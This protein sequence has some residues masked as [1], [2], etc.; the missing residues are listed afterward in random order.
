M[1][2][3]DRMSWWLALALL[4]IGST[5]LLLPGLF[6]GPSRDPAVF[7]AVARAILNGHVPYA[8]IWD[9]KAPGI[10]LI[11]AVA[12]LMTGSAG[13]LWPAAWLASLAATVAAACAA[14]VL[15]RRLGVRPMVAVL[16]GLATAGAS[17]QYAL[18]EGG[19][20]TEQA[21]L[22]FGAWALVAAVGASRR[23]LAAAGALSAL[24]LGTTPLLAPAVAAATAAVVV[25][26]RGSRA[27]ARLGWFAAGASAPIAM[28]L[29]WL[30]LRGGLPSAWDAIVTYNAAYRVTQAHVLD[31]SIA[32]VRT[33]A[34][35]LAFVLIPAALGSRTLA[36]RWKRTRSGLEVAI[37]I[38][39]AGGILMVAVQG[40]VYAHY[41]IP[42]AV[43]IAVLGSVGVEQLPAGWKRGAR[44]LTVATGSVCTVAV[45]VSLVT[46]TVRGA[47]LTAYNAAR[48]ARIGEVASEIDT[49]SSPGSTLFIWGNEPRLYEVARRAPAVRY[50]YLYPLTTPDYSTPDQVA[51]LVAS[52]ERAPPQIVVDAG[53]P[54]PGAPGVP[55]LLVSRPP[56]REGRN[57]DLLAPLR[58]FVAAHYSLAPRD[59]GWPI[60]TWS[61]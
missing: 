11:D 49:L 29:T 34:A 37:A 14:V 27:P 9:H 61:H 26:R 16:G 60:Y 42:L 56:D 6:V 19:G 31:R 24:A 28:V 1:T 2:R 33:V 54:V 39:L 23:S 3:A 47:Y 13:D 12:G 55:P 17:A 48:S 22:A 10:Y 40:L 45:L 57:L 52:F 38:W 8:D 18:A 50:V 53:S 32:V 30:S 5:L 36:A 41:L 25:G 43:P 58:E 15:A 44:V 35:P 20:F 4:T 46:G 51:A 21:A 59:L 7:T